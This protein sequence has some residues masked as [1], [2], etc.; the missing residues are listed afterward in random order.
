MLP[1][2]ATTSDITGLSQPQQPQKNQIFTFSTFFSVTVD[3]LH[4]R[5]IIPSTNLRAQ[6][7]GQVAHL[8][9]VQEFYDWAYEI[10]IMF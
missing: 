10:I 6:L 8:Q 1:T 7:T 4:F 2:E 3:N 9:T 5:N